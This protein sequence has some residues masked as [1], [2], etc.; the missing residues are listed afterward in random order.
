MTEPSRN[1]PPGQEMALSPADGSADGR[2]D[3]SA[4]GRRA[5][6]GTAAHSPGHQGAALSPEPSAP[7]RPAVFSSLLFVDAAGRSCAEDQADRA[8]VSDLHLDQIIDAA[9]GDREERDL[10]T[11]L[12]YQRILDIGTLQYRHEVFRDL[13]DPGL[14]EIAKRFAEQMRQVRSHLSQLQKMHSGHQREG[15]FLDAA[16][17]YCEAVRSLASDLASRPIASRGLLA[18]RGFLASYV[19]SAEFTGLASDTTARKD[20]VAQVMYQIRIKGLRVEA[21]ASAGG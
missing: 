11:G 14:F 20:D 18:F 5:S 9:A 3:V 4:D 10:L 13:E 1:T 2:A 21:P 7:G 8:F 16:A 12:F 6:A 17:I 19:A 15:W